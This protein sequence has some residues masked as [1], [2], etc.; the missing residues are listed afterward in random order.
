MKDL[1]VTY[2]LECTA[3]EVEARAQAIA[4]EQSIEMPPEAVRSSRVREEVIGEVREIEADGPSFWCGSAC[5][6][7]R[8]ATMPDSFSTCCS[9]TPR[10]KPDVSLL[11]FEPAAAAMAE[12]GG[13]R[14]GIEGLRARVGV[15]GRPL[16]CS[17][18]KP[19]GSTAAELA[20]IAAALARGGVDLIKDDHGLANQA[21]APFAERV[22]AVQAA[23][24]E[25]NRCSGGRT[26][27]APSLTGGPDELLA[28]YRLAREAGAGMVMLAPMIS[29]LSALQ[30]LAASEA[31]LPILA[32]PAMAGAARLTAGI[33]RQALS[34]G[35]RG[36][37]D[38]PESWRKV[39]LFARDLHRA[40]P[41]AAPFGR[42][43][44]RH[45]GA[46]GE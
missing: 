36:C 30:R 28:R 13:P 35:G 31:G 23:I 18:L 44:A 26:L 3:A 4:V 38:F 32:H 16:T 9:A 11:D 2:R 10:C 46:G 42:F 22:E 14:F 40:G 12:F 39:Q 6:L 33:D 5:R 8:P 45:A 21:F 29:G 24:A 20:Q 15:I 25:A 1:Q 19:Q 34:P 17:A 27:Y 37:D 7:Q 41:R 43:A